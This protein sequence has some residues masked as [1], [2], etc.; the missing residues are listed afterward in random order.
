MVSGA[1]EIRPYWEKDVNT[2]TQWGEAS[3]SI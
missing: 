1:D 3:L 2:P